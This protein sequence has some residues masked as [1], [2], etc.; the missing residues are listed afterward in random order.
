MHFCVPQRCYNSRPVRG[1]E[2]VIVRSRFASSPPACLD[3][4]SVG[5]A[6]RASLFAR[7][8]GAGAGVRIAGTVRERAIGTALTA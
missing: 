6:V 8:R 3:V 2:L 5:V 1:L 7:R 4:G